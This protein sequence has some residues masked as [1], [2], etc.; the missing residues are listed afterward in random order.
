MPARSAAVWAAGPTTPTLIPF[1]CGLWHVPMMQAANR[2][3]KK[4]G[5]SIALSA[6]RLLALLVPDGGVG[7][8]VHAR[9]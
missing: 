2:T 9:T 1:G 7:S 8:V 4:S 3:T 6:R 5:M